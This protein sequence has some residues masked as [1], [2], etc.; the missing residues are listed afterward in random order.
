M[1][2]LNRVSKGNLTN[3]S[4][5][6]PVFEL[7]DDRLEISAYATP[8]TKILAQQ[9]SLCTVLTY[10]YENNPQLNKPILALA[11]KNINSAN[12]T[13]STAGSNNKYRL[14]VI[15]KLFC[16]WQRN[17]KNSNKYNSTIIPNDTTVRDD[18]SYHADTTATWDGSSTL[19]L[20][21]I[22]RNAEFIKYLTSSLD[23]I[24]YIKEFE[25]IDHLEAVVIKTKEEI[26]AAMKATT[27]TALPKVNTSPTK[28]PARTQANV[29]APATKRNHNNVA[30]EIVGDED[31]QLD[32]KIVISFE[33][34]NISITQRSYD[35]IKNILLSEGILLEQETKTILKNT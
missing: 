29:K 3:A 15:I 25:M 26:E 6:L 2:T 10:L 12:C 21:F 20:N 30:E 22:I 13:F 5:C 31:T 28:K 11:D 9:L 19:Q 35:E 1:Q 24:Y 8:K 17:F 32:T 16:E 33:L 14:G 7:Y 23:G 18:L 4:G 27:K 34:G